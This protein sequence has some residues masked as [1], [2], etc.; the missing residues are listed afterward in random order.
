VQIPYSGED[1]MAQPFVESFQLAQGIS[2]E[3]YNMILDNWLRGGYGHEYKVKERRPDFIHIY[4]SFTPT[5]AYFWL[6]CGLL[7]GL[8]CILTSKKELRIRLSVTPGDAGLIVNAQVKGSLKDLM[9]EYHDLK[10]QL[11]GAFGSQAG[12]PGPVGPSGPSGPGNDQW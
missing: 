1:V 2:I 11:Q 6:L 8:I 5:S 3:Q 7:P 4:K 10:Y 12:G 9:G